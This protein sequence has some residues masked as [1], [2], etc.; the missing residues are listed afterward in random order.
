MA[1]LLAL[2]LIRHTAVPG[3]LHSF[4]A[5]DWAAALGC[6]P[7]GRSERPERLRLRQE[8]QAALRRGDGGLND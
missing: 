8:I 2:T 1:K 4:Y 6:R 7:Q 3:S 5:F